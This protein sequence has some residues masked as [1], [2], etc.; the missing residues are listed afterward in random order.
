MTQQQ[1]TE[2]LNT[3]AAIAKLVILITDEKILIDTVRQL[4]QCDEEKANLLITKGKLLISRI[5]N[6]GDKVSIDH[7]L[8]KLV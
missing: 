3:Y 1:A 2:I 7:P 5:M 6:M 8:L 4:Y